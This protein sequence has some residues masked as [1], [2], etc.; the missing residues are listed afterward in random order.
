MNIFEFVLKL[1]GYNLNDAEKKIKYLQSLNKNDFINWQ[2]TEKWKIVR[3]H[4]NKNPL[5]KEKIGPVFP[6]K[7]EDIP[8]MEKQ[9]FQGK[10][11]NSLSSGYSKEDCYVAN[12][13]GSTGTPLIFAKNKSA[14]AMCWALIKN[15]YS[16]HNLTL[17][18]KQARF[19]GIPLEFSSYYKEKFKDIIMNRVRFS[20]YGLSDE[21][22]SNYVKKFKKTKFQYCYGYT[23]SLVLFARYLIKKKIILS[24]IC[25]T[26]EC[27]ITTSE[28]LI[29]EDRE[30]LFKAFGVKIINEYGMSEVGSITFEDNDRNWL[31][32]DEVSFYE[33]MPSTANNHDHNLPFGKILITD[34]YNYAMPFIRYNIGDLGIISNTLHEKRNNKRLLK[35]IGREN[36]LIY[37]PSGEISPGFTLYYV[38][39]DILESDIILTEYLIRQIKIDN[40]I[41]EYVKN[42]PL[43]NEEK[44]VVRKIIFKYLESGLNIILKVFQ[45]LKKILLGNLNIF[46][47][48]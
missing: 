35:L 27:C 3:H 9:D 33:I 48:N 1:K 5:Y 26:L 39:R 6:D 41:F 24:E 43:T 4:Y 46:Y 36:D 14:H 13:S 45:E 15:R 29:E 8:I 25:P 30:I 20:I 23:N 37:L 44:E 32:P 22:L 42:N 47:L 40:F 17:R 19:Y 28:I 38:S 16:W 21:K 34:L 11:L 31:I 12:T 18:S 2:N 7:W 10:F